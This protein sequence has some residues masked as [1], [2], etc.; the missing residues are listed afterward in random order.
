MRNEKELKLTLAPLKKMAAT[1]QFSW[2]FQIIFF[3]FKTKRRIFVKRKSQ[4]YLP[5]CY[6]KVT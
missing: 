3:N 1:L 6:Q 5:D 2:F 4:P